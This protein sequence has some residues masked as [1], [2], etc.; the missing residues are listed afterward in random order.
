[1]A[2]GARSVAVDI[3]FD[4]RSDSPQDDR[5]LQQTLQRYAGR[6]TLAANQATSVQDGENGLEQLAYPDPMFQTKPK[7]IGLISYLL[8]PNEQYRRFGWV[9]I[10]EQIDPDLRKSHSDLISFTEATLKAAN[11]PVAPRKETIS[12]SMDEKIR[13]ARSRSGVFWILTNGNNC[14]ENKTLRTKSF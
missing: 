2:A 3:V 7:S 4:S 12:S 11:L 8:E 9:A 10:Q 14:S 6:V 13:F 5:R 1:M